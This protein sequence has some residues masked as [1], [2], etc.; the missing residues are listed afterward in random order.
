MF[1]FALWDERAE[2]LF[3][4]RDRLGKKPLFYAEL[5]TGR[6][7]FGSELKAILVDPEISRDIDPYAVD[8]F[9][10]YGYIPDPR[11]IYRSVT[12]LPPAHTLLVRR[13]SRPRLSRY[14]DLAFAPRAIAKPR[15]AKG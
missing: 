12:K 14:W 10:A 9:F 8:D 1:A 6:I 2:T 4:A 13:G 15:H 11:T 3:L 7:V 5:P